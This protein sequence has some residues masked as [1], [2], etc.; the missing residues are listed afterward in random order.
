MLRL[1]H[2]P[3]GKEEKGS[4]IGA[5]KYSLGADVLAAIAKA[6]DDLRMHR[7]RE[8]HGIELMNPQVGHRGGKL[9]EAYVGEARPSDPRGAAGNRRLVLLVQSG[10]I[11]EMYFSD[12]HYLPGSWTRIIDF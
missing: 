10:R 4:M 12:S 11:T 9:F 3:K 6:K 2:T 5:S 8:Y 1:W 7:L